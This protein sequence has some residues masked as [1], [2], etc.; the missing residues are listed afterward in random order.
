MNSRML[1]G[2]RN[3]LRAAVATAITLVSALSMSCAY[4]AS[5]PIVVLGD[6]LSAEYGLPRGAG[7]VTLLQ[8]RLATEKIDAPI[9]N[10]SISGE[11]TSGGVTRLP[12]LL[13]KEK[14]S[15]VIIELGANDGLR[16]LSLAA[17]ETNL[18]TMITA[19]QAA[20]AKVLLVGMQ[21]PPNYGPDYTNKFA[22]LYGRL[23]K[24]AKT[25]LVPFLFAGMADKPQLFQADHLHPT[26]QAQPILLDNVWLSLK[27]MLTK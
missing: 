5:K 23:A 25:A 7:W 17:A 12:Q 22:A 11:T 19:A 3:I 14:P 10:A 20:H 15:I 13:Q 9:Y 27:P 26:V 4:S 16:G 24:D 18:R 6:S 1:G 21:L 8:E 2:R